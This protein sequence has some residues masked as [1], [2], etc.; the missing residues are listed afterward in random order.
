MNKNPEMQGDAATEKTKRPAEAVDDKAKTVELGPD[1]N[2]VMAEATIE[3]KM[4]DGSVVETTVVPKKKKHTGL[5]VLIVILILVLLGAGGFAAWYFLCH[6]NSENIAYSAVNSLLQAKDVTISG[7]LVGTIE[8]ENGNNLQLFATLEGD[9]S[10]VAGASTLLVMLS[11][12][13]ANGSALR[14]PYRFELGNVVMADGVFYIKLNE[15]AETFDQLVAEG[16]IP[17]RDLYGL[18]DAIGQVLDAVDGEWWQISVPDLIDLVTDNDQD[19]KPAKE[20]YTCIVNVANQDV[21]GEL[22]RIY[23]GNRFVNV[24]KAT[25]VTSYTEID[26]ST[27]YDVSFNYD[28]MASFINALPSSETAQGVYNCYNHYLDA[29]GD[30]NA[31]RLSADSAD[32]ITADDLRESIPENADIKMHISDWDH[33]L[34][35]LSIRDEGDTDTLLTLAFKYEATEVKAPES[36]R[37]ISE[38]FEELVEIVAGVLG[39]IQSG[40]GGGVTYDPETELIYDPVTN[41]WYEVE[42]YLAMYQTI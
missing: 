15:L 13:D 36:Y 24:T 22:A 20:F 6:N 33:K 9:Q 16:T 29:S 32:A 25:N 34:T 2:L 31:E 7:S 11:P 17:E 10:G 8:V 28:T 37:P 4:P 30:T 23:G 21:K 19:A 42:D 27:L 14:E 5:V 12:V 38:L 39:S 26:G 3:T 41:A 40:T 35:S 18:T 1:D